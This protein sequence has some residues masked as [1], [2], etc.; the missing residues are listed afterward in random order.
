MRA[1]GEHVTRGAG[2]GQ[3]HMVALAD[4]LHAGG[5]GGLVAAHQRGDADIG[6][7]AL[8]FGGG[9]FLV[10]L[11][12]AVVQFDLRAAHR[13]DAAAIID[14]GDSELDA[15]LGILGDRCRGAGVREQHAQLDHLFLLGDRTGGQCQYHGEYEKYSQQFLSPFYYFICLGR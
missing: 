6:D 15:L 13:L 7:Q 8:G 5:D 14:L 10:G 11:G 3:R 12:I 9:G 2:D 1:L 4:G